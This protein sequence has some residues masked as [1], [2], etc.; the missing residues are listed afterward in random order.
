M[1]DDQV[2]VKFGAQ[3]S[4]L[5]AGVDAVKESVEGLRAPFD[6]LKAGLARAFEAAGVAIALGKL[7]EFGAEMAEIGERALNTGSALG[8]TVR[9]VGELQGMFTLAGG[10]ADMAQRS[11]ERLGLSLRQ[12]LENPTGMAATAFKNLGISIDEMKAHANDLPGLLKLIVDRAAESGTPLQRMAVL[13]QLI[14]R[15]FDTLIPL[16]SQGATGWQE[17]RQR[18]QDYTAALERSAAGA[19]DS[20]ERM[21]RLTLDTRTLADDGFGLLKPA[22]DGGRDCLDATLGAFDGAIRAVQGLQV[23]LSPLAASFYAVFKAVVDTAAIIDGF[24]R[25]TEVALGQAGAFAQSLSNVAHGVLFVSNTLL[26]GD[27]AGLGEAM[28]HGWDLAAGHAHETAAAMRRDL[29]ALLADIWSLGTAAASGGAQPGAAPLPT[30]AGRPIGIEKPG[31]GG[32]GRGRA[33]DDE[34]KALDREIAAETRLRIEALEAEKRAAD[35]DFDS[36]IA[37]L[38]A[39]VRE[40][41]IAAA[42]ALKQEQLLNTQKW[43]SDENYLRQKLALYAGDAAGMQSVQDEELVQT[44]AFNA[45]MVALADKAA[46]QTQQSWKQSIQQ[47]SNAFATFATDVI[48]RTKSLAKAFDEMVRS[49]LD[50]FLKST[51][52][53]AFNE[54]LFGSSGS[55]GGGSGGLFGN[56]GGDL[57]KALFGDAFK[58]L[59]GNPFSSTSG[60]LLGGLLPLGG[61]AAGGGFFSWLG[62]LLGFERGGVVRSAAGGWVVPHFQSGGILSM[63]HQ[64]EMVL[65]APISQG[66]QDLIAS[67]GGGHTI[68]INAVDA[69]GVARLFANN[70]SA[71]VAALNRAMRNGSMLVQPS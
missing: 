34:A 27:N 67:G 65:P 36:Q 63:L 64:N 51:F 14:G 41:K 24:V 5:L 10:D 40:G 45:K 17:L 53:G 60:G 43:S 20:A 55:S 9:Q 68:N 25:S 49:I 47:L 56:L 12:S 23:E 15:G 8:L 44:A 33:D 18:A 70:G 3:T 4:G 31:G 1:P 48:L 30:G 61:G 22:I 58:G 6:S 2:N 66:L 28:A 71:L 13:D 7:R 37:H 35:I 54:L 42:D 46:E 19:A 62:G 26:H 52:K 57:V 11:I 29:Q 21:N 50:D 39:L 59:I 32:E 16:L 69:A 38:Q